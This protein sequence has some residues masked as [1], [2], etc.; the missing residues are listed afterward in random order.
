MAGNTNCIIIENMPICLRVLGL[1]LSLPEDISDA[2][3]TIYD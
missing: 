1:D 2:I 3:Q